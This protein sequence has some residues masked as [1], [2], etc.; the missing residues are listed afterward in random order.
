M[1]SRRLPKTDTMVSKENTSLRNKVK[2]LEASLEQAYKDIN[3]PNRGYCAIIEKL[4]KEN[5]ALKKDNSLLEETCN[6]EL[7]DA[8]RGYCGIIVKLQ[9][10]NKGLKLGKEMLERACELYNESG[11][12]YAE[13]YYSMM[14]QIAVMENQKKES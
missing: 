11:D 12:F 3:D 10:E 1:T 2:C 14:E 13:G 9:K 4:Q 7:N 6:R 8:D 5:A